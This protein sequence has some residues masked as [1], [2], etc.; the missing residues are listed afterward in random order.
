MTTWIGQ[1]LERREDSR[2]LRGAAH[3]LDDL[4]F[5]RLGYVAILRSPHAHAEI[6]EINVEAARKARGV[7][8]VITGSDVI[9]ASK[10]F[11]VGPTWMRP[12]VYYMLAVDRVRF[13]G[14]P[15][16]AV[17]AETQALAEDALEYIVVNYE[18]LE[19][20]TNPQEA[21]RSD[22]PKL[23]SEWPDNVVA[24]R[25]FSI[26][27]V[28]EMFETAP[29]VV[30]E[31]FVS[32]R[33]TALPLEL[34]GCVAAW[35]EGSLVLWSSTQVPH[36]LRSVTSEVLGVPER[37]I[38]VVAPDVGGGFGTKCHVFREEP[39][40][41]FLARIVG[42]PVKWREDIREHLS[43]SLH[44]R[45]Q[46][47]SLDIAADRDGVILAMRAHVIGDV[48]AGM[49]NPPSASP[50][51]IVAASCPLGLRVQ[52]FSFSVECFVTNKCPGGAYRGF[53]NP[54]R[55]LAV[56]RC[57]DI[58]AQ[59]VG[60]DPAEVRRRNLVRKQEMPFR[61]ATGAR[62]YSGS[63]IESMDRAL[64]LANYEEMRRHQQDLRAQGRYL[65]I[66]ITS[67]AEGTGPSWEGHTGT[68]GAYD[69]CTVRIEPDGQV[70]VNVGI[71][72]QG[73]GTATAVAQIVAD[74]LSTT[75]EAI[76]VKFGDT[77][78]GPFGLGNWGSRGLTVAAGSS[79]AAALELRTKLIDVAAH[80]HECAS[81]DIRLDKGR[82]WIV[83]SDR[84]VSFHELATAAYGG[85]GRR[86]ANMSPGLEVTNYFEPEAIERQADREGRIM[87]YAAISNAA[88]VALVEVLLESGEVRILDY[89]V[90]HDCGTVINPAI[91][92]GQIRGG[93]V[94]GIAG[95]LHES[96]AY[97]DAGQLLT[98][99]LMDYHVPR[100]V[101]IP[102]FRIEH[103]ES[104]DPTIPLGVKG[105][106]ES[107]TIGA[108]V[109]IANAVADALAPLGVQIFQTG[110]TPPVLMNLIE[111]AH[112]KSEAAVKP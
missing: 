18:P 41:A 48:G 76:T 7:L 73:Q 92:D 12:L 67:F 111:Q 4:E 86:P 105:V 38:R 24:V 19:A 74:A 107:G 49:A 37:E 53:G 110:L 79:N 104:P 39:L 59:R 81:Q 102:N 40:I 8:A 69:A 44:A 6:R 10:S 47:I 95:A 54:V 58:L 14:D 31:T 15:I 75:P 60:I 88:H 62:I 89:V 33:Q 103:F 80:L 46:Q 29:I 94:Q 70:T 96:I 109:A 11:P 28:E 2:L 93:V 9:K 78:A 84:S 77:S 82:A 83:G 56:E 42:R 5:P 16:A 30:S 43:A 1:R 55:A 72:D 22:A 87:R 32:Q 71:C 108:P 57:L 3:Y 68:L 64:E 51:M 34:R 66:G 36:M 112:R 61:S 65:G 25:K 106:G 13:V 27:Q 52:H 20:I 97:D 98:G 63:F 91:V 90:V 26:G 101:E 23:Y 85:R 50:V 45:D 100:A 99:T 35:N 21:R 17:V